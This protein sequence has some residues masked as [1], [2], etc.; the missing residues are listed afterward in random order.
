MRS[1]KR[2]STMDRATDFIFA[3]FNIA[4]SRDVP[5]RQPQQLQCKG[6]PLCPFVFL[7]YRLGVD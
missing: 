3:L 2:I 6:S 5:F 4:S 1:A 7:L